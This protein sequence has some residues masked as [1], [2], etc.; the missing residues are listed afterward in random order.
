V[1]SHAFVTTWQVPKG[2]RNWDNPHRTEYLRTHSIPFKQ[3]KI[4]G[5]GQRIIVKA[6][7]VQ[8]LNRSIIIYDKASYFAATA[9]EGK[10]TALALHL[11]IIKHIERLLHVEF[12]IG[13]DHKFRVSRQHQALIHNTLAEQYN[14]TGEKLEV[15]NGKG[16]WLLID[17]SFGMNELEGVHHT[18]ATTDNMKVQD[19]FN[20]LKNIP[21]IKG[22]PTYTPA[23]VLEMI[24]G[25]TTN[26]AVF[27]ENMISH[28]D[29]VQS[30]SAGVKDMNRVLKQIMEKVQ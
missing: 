7:K 5:G 8:L 26:Q 4:A 30:L 18:T 16:L 3:L 27:A 22:A 11:S 13:D 12:L 17:N 10:S 19:F 6:R 25:I 14:K 20:G 28:I 21:A 24:A 1:R 23:T 29:A 9:L 2:L 15:R